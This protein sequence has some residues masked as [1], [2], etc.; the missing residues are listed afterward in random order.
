MKLIQFMRSWSEVWA[1]LIPLIVIVIHKPKELN[2]RPLVWY[3]F[4]AFILN[5]TAT[6]MVEYYYLLPADLQNNN[7]LY[8]LHSFARVILFSWYLSKITPRQFA[9]I[10]KTTLLVYIIFVLVNFRFFESP[11]ILSTRL[12]AAESIIL[13][14]ICI[15][16][17]LR[18]MQDES[19]TNWISHPSFLVCTGISMY[20]A[21]TFFIFLFIYP[22]A[23]KNPE[24]GKI[25]MEIY[26]IIFIIFCILLALALYRSKKESAVIHRT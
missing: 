8:N 7:V 23:E 16:F 17:F 3:V 25:S 6:F 10:Y 9:F 22:I 24:F 18:S 12:F 21:I 14:F 20:E 13:L 19:G 1:L 15:S 4:I 2:I 5:F 26:Q 11:F